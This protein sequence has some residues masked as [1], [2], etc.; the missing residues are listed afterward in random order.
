MLVNLQYMVSQEWVDKGVSM[1]SEEKEFDEGLIKGTFYEAHYDPHHEFWASKFDPSTNRGTRVMSILQTPT[2]GI[3]AGYCAEHVINNFTDYEV[4]E[5][6]GFINKDGLI[7]SREDFQAFFND[8]DIE[9]LPSGRK[10]PLSGH[11]HD[12]YGVADNLQQIL[13]KYKQ[14]LSS[15]EEVVLCYHPVYKKD[16]SSDGGWRWHKNGAYIGNKRS[17]ERHEYLYDEPDVEMVLCFNFIKVKK[18]ENL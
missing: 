10:A 14:L 3:L 11:F 1:R 15:T 7:Y 2:P 18:K 5:E 12:S 13:K 17:K 4:V 9:I 8:R 6:Y 16:Q